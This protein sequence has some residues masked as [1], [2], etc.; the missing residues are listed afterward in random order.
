[1]T[2]RVVLADDQA[3]VR[4]GFHALLDRT[5]DI[6]VVGEAADG[7]AAIASVR[8]RRPDVVLM[9]VRM[10]VLD[11]IEATRR[12]TADPSLPDVKVLVLT[13]FEVDE[14]VFE[15]LRAG[16]SGF[17]LK[18]VEPDDLRQAV[19][20][21]ADGQALLSPSV[22]RRVIA[23]FSQRPQRAAPDQSR[24]APLTDR[25]REVVA[26]VARGLTNEEIAVRL[27]MSPATAKTHI[28]R[29]MTKVGARDRAQLVV[30]AYESGLVEP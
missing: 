5:E 11:G 22:T 9:D 19:R 30:L 18:D 15:A 10:P 14:Y 2:I 3:L 4:A 29:A 13:T 21:V 24:L 7:A 26:F 20:L 1:M 28:N 17:L 23:E 16:A 6:E 8:D 25:E 12:I 27:H